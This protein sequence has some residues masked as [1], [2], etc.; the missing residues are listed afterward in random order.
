MSIFSLFLQ[1]E[2]ED[3]EKSRDLLSF[4]L[5]HCE[6]SSIE[7][8]LQSLL[9]LEQRSLSR[10]LQLRAGGPGMKNGAPEVED[11][12]VDVYEDTCEEVR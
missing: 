3:M 8:I 11:E 7:D 9:R 6:E 2:F 4:A 1:A 5:T 10:S 12:G